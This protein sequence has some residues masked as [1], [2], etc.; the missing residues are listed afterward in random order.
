VFPRPGRLRGGRF[1]RL[2]PLESLFSCWPKRKVTQRKWPPEQGLAASCWDKPERLRIV[3]AG[4]PWEATQRAL[5]SAA[6]RARIAEDLKR[7]LALHRLLLWLRSSRSYAMHRTSPSPLVGEGRGEGRAR[8]SAANSRFVL[9]SPG[10]LFFWHCHHLGGYF[11]LG[12]QR[13]VTRRPAGRRKPAVGEP[14]GD[15][16]TTED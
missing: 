3:V 1:D 5:P 2:P 6:Q 4:H 7:S 16:A 9:G 13:K 10:Y 15:I 12:K 11:S 14:G 8:E